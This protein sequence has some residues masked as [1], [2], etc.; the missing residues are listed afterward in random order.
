MRAACLKPQGMLCRFA[1]HQVDTNTYARVMMVSG[2]HHVGM[3]AKTDMKAGEELKYDY[4]YHSGEGYCP[5]WGDITHRPPKQGS[6][7]GA[8][9]RD[10]SQ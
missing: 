2:D 4:G 10:H 1:N 3:Y 9:A 6:D 5:R 7:S 8:R